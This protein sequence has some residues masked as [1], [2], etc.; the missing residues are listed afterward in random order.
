MHINKKQKEKKRKI[1]LEK[2][3]S[4]NLEEVYLKP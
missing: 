3:P 2:N 4:P 1:N